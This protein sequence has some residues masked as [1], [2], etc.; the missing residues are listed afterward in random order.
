M[1]KFLAVL[2]AVMMV[3]S[4]VVTMIVSVGA[5]A[6]VASDTPNSILVSDG[7]DAAEEFYNPAKPGWSLTN[8]GNNDNTY[9]VVDVVTGKETE[10]AVGDV[11]TGPATFPVIGYRFHYWAAE[12][13]DI[14][15]MKYVEFDLYLSDATAY[16]G[17]TMIV[18]LA[19]G[20]ID[21]D[22]ISF[23]AKY[24]LVNGWNH[25]RLN[26]EDNFTVGETLAGGF[27]SYVEGAPEFFELQS[28][29]IAI[30]KAENGGANDY[31]L[32]ISTR[33]D[34]TIMVG[35][36]GAYKVEALEYPITITPAVTQ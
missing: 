4:T 15:G 19:S 13:L 36:S 5:V 22:E 1:K 17:K 20:G 32:I 11:I 8:N 14:S 18:E 16:Q 24:P 10:K 2:L 9:K 35:E 28:G 7:T 27:T 3:F 6:T 34:E 30:T 26:I 25:I 29:R 23:E 12:T 21:N 31:L 33:G